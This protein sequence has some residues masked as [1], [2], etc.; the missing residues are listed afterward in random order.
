MRTIARSI[1]RGLL[2]LALLVAAV[3]PVYAAANIIILNNDGAGEG[4]NDPT[5][6]VPVGGNIGVTVGEQRHAAV[7]AGLAVS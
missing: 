7:S 1:L 4:F 3:G 5:P 2:P 6:A